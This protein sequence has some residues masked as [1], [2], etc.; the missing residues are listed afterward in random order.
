[1][2]WS[3]GDAELKPSSQFHSWLSIWLSDFISYKGD[4]IYNLYPLPPPPLHYMCAWTYPCY[5]MPVNVTVQLWESTLSTQ[6]TDKWAQIEQPCASHTFLCFAGLSS[7]IL[8]YFL[9]FLHL[10]LHS[11]KW[12]MSI[13]VFS[14]ISQFLLYELPGRWRGVS[15]F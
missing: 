3:C 1:M 5:C 14:E 4:Y 8:K 13:I 12:D 11:C 10:P 7:I 2:N 6:H 15:I 9:P